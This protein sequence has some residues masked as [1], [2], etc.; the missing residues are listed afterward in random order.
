MACAA[1]QIH[2]HLI[3]TASVITGSQQ[4]KVCQQQHNTQCNL[5]SEVWE[6]KMYADLNSTFVDREVVSSRAS[7]HKKFNRSRIERKKNVNK[8]VR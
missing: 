8:I 1:K 7:A 4:N 3:M 5:T 2:M 6:D